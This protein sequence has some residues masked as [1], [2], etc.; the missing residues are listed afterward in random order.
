MQ[1]FHLYPKQESLT[2]FVLLPDLIRDQ[3]LDLG[4]SHLRQT[5]II[6][7]YMGFLVFKHLST[8]LNSL[9]LFHRQ[10]I[11]NIQS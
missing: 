8:I 2:L 11:I 9:I 1:H 3:A 6:T 7:F 4:L 5:T 10:R